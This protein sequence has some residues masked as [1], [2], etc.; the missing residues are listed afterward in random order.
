MILKDKVCIDCGIS[1]T[2]SGRAQLRCV[3]CGKEHAIQI[4]KEYNRRSTINRR[5]DRDKDNKRRR[6]YNFKVKME[7]LTYYCAGEPFCWCC[8]EKNIEFLTIHHINNDGAKQK[9][10]ESGLKSF[11]RARRDGFPDD[12]GILCYNCNSSRGAIGYCPHQKQVE[13]N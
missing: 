5:L 9:K 1:Y 12:L 11:Q 2:P 6:E 10:E 3:D 13:M 8:G 4:N 7:V